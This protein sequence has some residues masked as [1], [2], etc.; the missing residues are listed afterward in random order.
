[1]TPTSAAP[2]NFTIMVADVPGE[3]TPQTPCHEATPLE[4]D[5]LA[6]R[7]LY[8]ANGLPCPREALDAARAQFLSQQGEAD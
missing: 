3:I 8:A 6:V 7:A 1:M 5:L 2:P 4:F